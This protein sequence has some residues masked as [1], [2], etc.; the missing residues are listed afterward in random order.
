MG[1]LP[2]KIRSS[3]AGVATLGVFIDGLAKPG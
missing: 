3:R 1:F 2:L